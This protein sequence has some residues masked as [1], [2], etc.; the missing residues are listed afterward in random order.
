MSDT[1]SLKMF[2]ELILETYCN[3][4]MLSKK[5]VI[6]NIDEPKTSVPS[7]TIMF[8]FS[9][10]SG[11]PVHVCAI[12]PNMKYLSRN[13]CARVCNFSEESGDFLS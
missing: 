4:K 8:N 1:A 3:A 10:E 9:G 5:N 11:D 2:H 7:N 13:L 6:R 12:Q